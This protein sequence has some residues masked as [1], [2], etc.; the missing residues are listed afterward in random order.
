MSEKDNKGLEEVLN[1]R[2]QEFMAFEE[3]KER[4]VAFVRSCSMLKQGKPGSAN[5]FGY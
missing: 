1:K 5:H 2:C 3:E 4:I